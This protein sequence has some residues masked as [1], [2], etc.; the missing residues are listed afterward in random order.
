MPILW[1]P[2]AKNWLIEKT[3]MLGK[4]EGRRRGWQEWDGWMASPARWTWVWASSRS[5][6]WTWKSGMLQ[7]MGHKDL[8]MIEWLNWTELREQGSKKVDEP[9]AFSQESSTKGNLERIRGAPV[10]VLFLPPPRLL[11]I[12]FP[13]TDAEP[14]LTMSYSYL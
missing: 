6:W 12:F 3:L 14:F 10:K 13:P 8:D 4:I 11:M 9:Y 1:P 7:S 5:C 2:D